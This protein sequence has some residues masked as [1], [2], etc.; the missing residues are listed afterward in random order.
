MTLPLYKGKHPHAF[1]VKANS[2][3]WYDKFCDKWEPGWKIGA[4]KKKEWIQTV[5]TTNMG[6]EVLLQQYVDRFT[7]L[8]ETLGG[9]LVFM[10][11]AGRF[12]TGLGNAH[13]VENGFL[14]HHT[15]G[16]PYLPGSSVKGMVR[17]WVALAQKESVGGDIF[18]SAVNQGGE[19]GHVGDIIFFDAVPLVP[20]Q[21]EADVM[22]PHYDPYYQKKDSPPGDWYSP[23]P[24]PFLTVADGQK[25]IF[26]LASR[27]RDLEN[28]EQVVKWLMEALEYAGAGAKTSSGYGRFEVDEA[29]TRRYKQQQEERRR[30]EELMA[31]SPIKREM[32]TDGYGEAEFIEPLTVKWLPRIDSSSGQERVEIA[33]LLKE[34]YQKHRPEQWASPSGKNIDKV[35]KIKRILPSS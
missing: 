28:I 5:T 18:G 30:Q 10:K 26:A 22:T 25:F 8:I 32:I 9:K 2:G 23:I 33:Q 11:T 1:P 19:R 7:R 31:M 21:L 6:Y 27:S 20:I 29:E 4:A 34:W 12:V 3:L 15:L 14:W 35:Q 16:V 13:P 24:I 17:N